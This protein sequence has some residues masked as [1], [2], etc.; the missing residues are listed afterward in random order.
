MSILSE[1]K[2]YSLYQNK[3]QPSGLRDPRISHLSNRVRG[4]R[5]APGG[6]RPP[7]WQTYWGVVAGAGAGGAEGTGGQGGPEWGPGSRAKLLLP[8]S[9]CVF[10]DAT[11]RQRWHVTSNNIRSHQ[12][13]SALST[14]LKITAIITYLKGVKFQNSPLGPAST[15]Q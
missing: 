1:L 10:K 3:K 4:W 9:D 14:K 5:K 8:K 2:K 13:T 7:K 12:I 11:G 15:R 6:G